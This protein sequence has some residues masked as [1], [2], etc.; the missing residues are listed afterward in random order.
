MLQSVKSFT[1]LAKTK[2]QEDGYRIRS[3]EQQLVPIQNQSRP[4]KNETIQKSAIEFML[5]E[6][7]AIRVGKTRF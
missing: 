6:I 5:K 7:V 3:G 4:P 2:P 1:K